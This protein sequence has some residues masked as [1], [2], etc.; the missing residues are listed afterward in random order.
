VRVLQFVAVISLA[1]IGVLSAHADKRVALV[2]GNDRYANLP[3]SEQL[4]TAVN[5]ARAVGKA[6]EQIGFRRCPA[7]TLTSG[8]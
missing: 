5:D 6:L 3:A 1:L 4:Q 2:I 8:R 7:R